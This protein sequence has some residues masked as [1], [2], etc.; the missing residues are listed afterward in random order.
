MLV[1]LVYETGARV[2]EIL[3]L[4]G[5]DVAMDE[6]GARITIRRS[7]SQARVLRVVMYAPLLAQYLEL[8]SPGQMTRCSHASTTPTLST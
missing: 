6:R 7:K 5:R 1:A 8:R 3:R 4:R 2:G